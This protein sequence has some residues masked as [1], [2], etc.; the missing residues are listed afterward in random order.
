M[1]LRDHEDAVE[2]DLQRFYGVDLGDVWRGDLS[3]RRLWVLLSHLPP[4]SAV[5]S[6]ENKIPH[7]YALTDF[8]LMDLFRVLT[9]ED[10]PA[11]PGAGSSSAAAPEERSRS[12]IEQLREQRERL[13][14][15]RKESDGG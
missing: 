8:L 4:G 9:G 7:G 5:W 14:A 3:V 11:R 2:A 12:L 15:Q 13:V 1:L 10:H 6:L